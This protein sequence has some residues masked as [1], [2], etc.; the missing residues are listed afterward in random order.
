LRSTSR[1][2]PA[3][4]DE[5]VSLPTILLVWEVV[6]SPS[7]L[8]FWEISEEVIIVGGGARLVD[9]DLGVVFAEIVDDV[10]VLVTELEISEPGETFVVDGDA[11]CLWIRVRRGRI[12]LEKAKMETCHG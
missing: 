11:R 7:T 5:L 9:D 3:E 10:L 4:E 1:D 6:N 12:V 2:L 8:S